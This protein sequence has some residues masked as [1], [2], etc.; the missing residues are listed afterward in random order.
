MAPPAAM[1]PLD[2]DAK[3]ATPPRSRTHHP[4]QGGGRGLP[5]RKEVRGGRHHAR[6]VV[7]PGVGRRWLPRW[8]FGGGRREE[9]RQRWFERKEALALALAL[10]F[11]LTLT[12]ALALA[13]AALRITTLA[14]ALAITFEI[15]TTKR[16]APVTRPWA[17]P[18]GRCLRRL[19]LC[20]RCTRSEPEALRGY[21]RPR[22][23]AIPLELCV[24]TTSTNKHA[25]Q[26]YR[27]VCS[28]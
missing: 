16:A 21:V 2:A 22:G 12:A 1:A 20:P 6:R 15:A 9:R 10:A 24:S 19:C 17:R 3:N 25:C 5:L 13:V 28:T 7:R 26:L 14:A 11:S 8:G 4:F 27:R 23:C 18:R